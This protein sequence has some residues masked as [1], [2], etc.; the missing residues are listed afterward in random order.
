MPDFLFFFISSA[1]PRDDF[2]DD[3]N[4]AGP[5]DPFNITSNYSCWMEDTVHLDLAVEPH[6]NMDEL[7]QAK[8]GTIQQAHSNLAEVGVKRCYTLAAVPPVIDLK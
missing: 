8:C 6:R 3:K 4:L 7:A 5:P 2:N 1:I